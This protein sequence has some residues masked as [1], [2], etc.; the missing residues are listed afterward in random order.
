MADTDVRSQRLQWIRD[1]SN[2]LVGISTGA[3]VLSATYFYDRFDRHPRLECLLVIAWILLIISALCGVFTSFSTWK[4]LQ[5]PPAAGSTEAALGGWVTRSYTTMMW[6][7]LG[8]YLLLAMSL[9]INVTIGGAPSEKQKVEIT[10]PPGVSAKNIHID[11]VAPTPAPA[12][13][14]H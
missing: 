10:L 4:D 11:V 3:L 5:A 1:G 8:G 7:F 13:A 9:L 12:T 6:T 14:A 2:W